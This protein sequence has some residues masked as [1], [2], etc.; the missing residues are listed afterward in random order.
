MKEDRNP[1]SV[2]KEDDIQTATVRNMDQKKLIESAE[3]YINISNLETI[4]CAFKDESEMANVIEEEVQEPLS[5]RELIQRDLV[6]YFQKIL[7]ENDTI[8]IAQQKEGQ[9]VRTRPADTD[10]LTTVQFEADDVSPAHFK[11][12]FDNFQEEAVK[13]NKETTS[14]TPVAVEDGKYNTLAQTFKFPMLS[15]R[16][17][18]N[19]M[20]AQYNYKD[21]KGTHLIIFSSKGNDKF[22][23]EQSLSKELVKKVRVINTISA[24]YMKPK[25]ERGI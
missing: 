22:W 17:V 21:Q 12:L 13:M 3:D 7:D 24:Y 1:F 16:I 4:E 10:F 8:P 15:E 2:V 5:E 23:N 11:H 19:T 6:D 25:G 20:Y 18:V 9:I 14:S